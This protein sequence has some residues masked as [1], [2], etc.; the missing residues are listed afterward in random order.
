[1]IEYW[2]QQIARLQME[3][4]RFINLQ[5]AL[6]S[7]VVPSINNVKGIM[8]S[9]D[10]SIKESFLVDNESEADLKY[11]TSELI[12]DSKTKTYK[13]KDIIKFYKVLPGQEFESK[14]EAS[15]KAKELGGVVYDPGTILGITKLKNSQ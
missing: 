10:S 12:L 11:E 1:M 9:A 3:K 8:E 13:Q 4:Q 15:I 6:S 7:S 2:R 14:K 5:N